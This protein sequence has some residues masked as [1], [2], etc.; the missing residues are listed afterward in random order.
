MP[1][2]DRFFRNGTRFGICMNFAGREAP[3]GGCQQK[4]PE[5]CPSGL[6]SSQLRDENQTTEARIFGI[7]SEKI[8][9]IWFS[10]I[11]RGGDSAMV[12]AVMRII[13]PTSWKPFSMAL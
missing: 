8:S 1:I 7:L 2:L 13:M 3:G 4:R 11:I 5:V 6:S 9:S 12:S 10:V